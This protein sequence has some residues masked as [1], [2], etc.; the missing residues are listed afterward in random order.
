MDETTRGEL[1]GHI[2]NE[3]HTAAGDRLISVNAEINGV[4]PACMA[5]EV[6]GRLHLATILH[7]RK[8]FPSDAQFAA[9][10][11]LRFAKGLDQLLADTSETSPGESADIIPFPAKGTL[12]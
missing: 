9:E 4:C 7:Y 1:A 3:L 11:V 8:H 2:A 10:M 5:P 12:Q 6:Y